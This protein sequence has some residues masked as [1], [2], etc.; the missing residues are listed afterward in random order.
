LGSARFANADDTESDASKLFFRQGTNAPVGFAFADAFRP[1]AVETL[2]KLKEFGIEVELLSG[3]RRAAV[4]AAADAAG[5]GAWRAETS[6]EEKT[7][8]IAALKA[9]GRRVL[10]LGDGLND[11]AALASATASIS[12]GDGA[13][14][15]QAAA[16]FVLQGSKLAPVVEAIRV[17]RAARA[18]IVENLWFSV[19]Y[20]ACA[21]PLAFA[22]LVTPLT[23]AIAMS[24]SSLIVT[25]NALRLARAAKD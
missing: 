18:R 22:G 8:R 4:A 6:P 1:D 14:V 3:D 9:D 11:A 19:L 23:A 5:V 25:L 7:A 10:M 21:V 20:N 15:T 24:G 16:D 13:D 2:Q 12:P 17:A